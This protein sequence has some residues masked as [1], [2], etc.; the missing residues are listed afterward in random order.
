MTWISN[1]VGVMIS[2]TGGISYLKKPVKVAVC[3]LIMTGYRMG[4]R[5]ESSLAFMELT[6]I[7]IGARAADQL[8]DLIERD[9]KK[10]KHK[11]TSL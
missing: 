4:D 11:R 7:E 8:M 9:E 3:V 2:R 10:N 1:P 6:G 5:L